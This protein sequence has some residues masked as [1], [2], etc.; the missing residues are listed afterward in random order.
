M[1][2]R[3]AAIAVAL[4]VLAA[5]G[6]WLVFWL[7][8]VDRGRYAHLATPE[9]I[10]GLNRAFAEMGDDVVLF[11][12]SHSEFI[13]DPSPLCGRSVINAGVGGVSARGAACDSCTRARAAQHATSACAT[14]GPSHPAG[15][16]RPGG[17]GGARAHSA[18][19]TLS[20]VCET[21]RSGRSRA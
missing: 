8:G 19:P 21:S 11:G 6:L 14:R 13:G 15:P 3:W 9:R 16:S 18:P 1:R 17:G 5:A 12:D 4:A 20:Y 10:A 7:E 2:R